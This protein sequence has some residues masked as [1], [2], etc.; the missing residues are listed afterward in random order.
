MGQKVSPRCREV[1][2]A[3]LNPLP[4][5][6]PTYEEIRKFDW[7]KG[8]EWKEHEQMIVKPTWRPEK[9]SKLVP[10]KRLPEEEAKRSVAVLI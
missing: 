10:R 8:I 5:R 2:E 9:D 6:R 1:I 4:E 3:C 7:F